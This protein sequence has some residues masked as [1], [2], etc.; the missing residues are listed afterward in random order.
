MRNAVGAR[1]LGE[2]LHS[3]FECFYPRSSYRNTIFNQSARVSISLGLFSKR[4]CCINHNDY[5]N[6]QGVGSSKTYLN[7]EHSANTIP[8]FETKMAILHILF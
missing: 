5:N 1:A 3:F 7:Q 4:W 2:C 8:G 6:Y